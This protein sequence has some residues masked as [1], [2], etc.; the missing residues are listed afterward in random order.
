MN[1]YNMFC[2]IFQGDTLSLIYSL[3]PNKSVY[4]MSSVK[5]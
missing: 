1:C 3:N 5:L 2:D 4:L